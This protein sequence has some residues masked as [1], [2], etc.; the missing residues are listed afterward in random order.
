VIS[1]LEA[2]CTRSAF[3]EAISATARA[4]A[5]DTI[6]IIYFAGHAEN[7]GE[8]FI[9]VT[10]DDSVDPARGVSGRDLEQALAP[11]RARGV[12][13]ILDCCGGA[14]I[15]ERAPLFFRMSQ[16]S[17][18]R[19]LVS[20]CRAGQSSWEYTDERRSAF[21]SR[22]LTVLGQ[23]DPFKSR[24]AI[25]FNDLYSDLHTWVLEETRNRLGP[26]HEQEPVFLGSHTREPLLL[27]QRGLTVAQARVRLERLTREEMRRRIRVA[28]GSLSLFVIAVFGAYWAWL[29][30]HSYL[31][32]QGDSIALVHGVPGHS[33]FGLPSTD[34]RYALTPDSLASDSALLHGGPVL[35]ARHA[36]P[37]TALM[38]QL[39][40][41]AR[42]RVA[43][44]RG[45]W[46]TARNLVLGSAAERK[47][48]S[49][50]SA[51][52]LP[53]LA[54]KADL[55]W[56][57][58]EFSTSPSTISNWLALALLDVNSEAAAGAFDRQAPHS[59]PIYA[60]NL[61]PTWNSACGPN[62]QRWLN[63]LLVEPASQ[64][65][66]P[67]Y[68]L[69]AL[70]SHCEVSL[71]AALVADNRF[72]RDVV[73]GLRLTNALGAESLD[74]ILTDGL[75]KVGGPVPNES[76]GTLARL[77]SFLRY[78]TS[79]VCPRALYASLDESDRDA[80]INA[81]LVITR[82]C[83][84]NT[85]R[86][87]RAAKEWRLELQKPGNNAPS[88]VTT[89]DIRSDPVGLLGICKT[90]AEARVAHADELLLDLLAASPDEFTRSAIVA[91]LRETGADGANAMRYV[92]AGAPHLKRELIL[93]LARSDSAA[94]VL[95][96]QNALG[97][98]HD[99][100]LLEV[101]GIIDMPL[102]ARHQFFE[103]AA[104]YEM[105]PRVI[106][107]TLTGE[108]G[109]VALLLTDRD[110]AVRST[111]R[112]YL[113][114]RDDWQS[115]LRFARTSLAQADPLSVEVKPLGKIRDKMVAS[116]K[117]TPPWALVWR[118]ERAESFEANN[119]GAQVALAH[120]LAQ[121]SVPHP[122]P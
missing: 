46:A 101:A 73:Y 83:S 25:Y 119:N 108:P 122:L 58:R 50:Q 16:S 63:R 107:Q 91:I 32:L 8:D 121:F 66:S 3:I 22:L 80:R 89:L 40:D 100:N 77:A 21:T 38:Q 116:V 18:F 43:L 5:P 70:R 9:L 86:L 60:L 15:F 65:Y 13:V 17:E 118:G 36:S 68:V 42:A 104:S 52:L 112:T 33:G 75:A 72:I 64:F 53:L 79:A 41:A 24:G 6:L 34:W 20:A 87:Q 114:A 120:A 92:T 99:S 10:A 67:N 93:W 117:A 19:I 103:A 1:L 96:L 85:L 54:T 47:A 4:T 71:Q 30:S 48:V 105:M 69:L 113:L 31:D 115:T 2:A 88:T 55:A 7:A 111:A 94:A 37:E 29:D 95:A 49:E 11:T 81:V 82:N 57:S 39:N 27:L 98:S 62:L 51:D 97:A 76:T 35:F 45:D 90:L 74:R 12:C 28:L 44:W 59:I 84:G 110:P 26:Q 78:S 23:R 14:A 109:D 61:M 56:L 106:L 102:S